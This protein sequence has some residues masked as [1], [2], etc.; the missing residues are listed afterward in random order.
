MG[1]EGDALVLQKPDDI[2][3]ILLAAAMVAVENLVGHMVH[4]PPEIPDEILGRHWQLLERVDVGRGVVG[5]E[6]LGRRLLVVIDGAVAVDVGRR[7]HFGDVVGAPEIIFRQGEEFEDGILA[8]AG[9]NSGRHVVDAE[10]EF[11][12]AV[13][14]GE[15][16]DLRE[17][18]HFIGVGLDCLT[19]V[20]A[21]M[22]VDVDV[23]IA[24]AVP[25]EVRREGEGDR[26]FGE[27]GIA[28]LVMLV[29]A[30]I[31]I[32]ENL[33]RFLDRA[34]VEDL[35]DIAG[36][37]HRAGEREQPVHHRDLVGVVGGE[38]L[39]N[40]QA[41]KFRFRFHHEDPVSLVLVDRIEPVGAHE[42][43]FGDI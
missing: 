13:L 29:E 11:V 39:E 28:G 16:L 31:L 33:P 17:L 27:K 15:G 36:I 8:L 34:G 35:A 32:L 37:G 14:P 18:F 25:G 41:R 26:G 3:D 22:V 7:I 42:V 19:K 38:R 40:D 20:E 10:D 24:D 21:A 23:G 1:E 2:V 4:A 30:D 6:D 9:E 5:G 12:E 43:Q